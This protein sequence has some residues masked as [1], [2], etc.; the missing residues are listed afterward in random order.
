MF[1]NAKL[2]PQRAAGAAKECSKNALQITLRRTGEKAT[3]NKA[4]KSMFWSKS[5]PAAKLTNL[6]QGL[7]NAGPNR[8]KSVRHW[9]DWEKLGQDLTK[10][11]EIE[12]SPVNNSGKHF[13]SNVRAPAANI[14]QLWSKSDHCWP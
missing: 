13:L 2:L 4:H 5:L 10:I 8:T 14:G 6:S 7:T 12:K 3:S 1:D 9:P 11:G